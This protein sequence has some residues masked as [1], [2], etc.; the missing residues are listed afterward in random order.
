MH[1]AVVSPAK[2]DKKLVA[3]FATERARLR[4]S[5][6]VWIRWLAPTYQARAFGYPFDMH[7]V[8]E[9]A[10][11]WKGKHAFVDL[12]GGRR[13]GQFVSAAGCSRSWRQGGRCRRSAVVLFQAGNLGSKGIFD[14]AGVGCG[15]AVLRVQALAAQ[16]TAASGEF[17]RLHLR[18]KKLAQRTGQSRC[19]GRPGFGL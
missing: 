4:E 5:Q 10:G 16:T 15:E 17:E 7:F 14:Q 12:A 6:M 19:D 1:F 13:G 11:F 9:P 18:K 3:D 2:G 8:S